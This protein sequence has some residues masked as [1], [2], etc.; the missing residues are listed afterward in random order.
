MSNKLTIMGWRSQGLRLPDYEVSLRRSSGAPYSITL[1]QMPNGTGKTTTL[2]LLRAALSGDLEKIGSVTQLEKRGGGEKSGL[3]EV[4]CSLNDKPYTYGIYIDFEEKVARIKTTRPT[5]QDDGHHVPPEF[6][7]FLRSNFVDFFVFDGELAESL[8]DSD[9]TN[10]QEALEALFHIDALKVMRSRIEE[11]WDDQVEH[12]TA[13]AERGLSRRRNRLKD[14][15]ARLG[16]L[17]DGYKDT[18]GRLREKRKKLNKLTEQYDAAIQKA[19]TW[20][21][22]VG[23]AQEAYV[24]ADEQLR[25]TSREVLDEMRN[26]VSL[27]DIFSDRCENLKLGLD[28]VKLPESAAREFFEEISNEEECI[29]GREIDASIASVIRERAASYLGNDDVALLN[30]IKS[31]ISEAVT[32]KRIDGRPLSKRLESVNVLSR[33]LSEAKTSLDALKNAAEEDDPALKEGRKKIEELN[34]EIRNLEEKEREFLSK[35]DS[36]GDQDT[37]GIDIIKRRIDD[38]EK[39]LTEIQEVMILKKKR[40]VLKDIFDKVVKGSLDALSK[41]IV[42]ETNSKLAAIIP[43]NEI[44]LSDIKKSLILKGQGGGSVGE[45]LSIA[46]SFLGTLFGHSNHELPLVV[47]SPAGPIDMQ[48]R[49][50]IAESIPRLT[51]QFIAFTI[52]SERQKFVDVLDN[53]PGSM[54]QYITLYRKSLSGVQRPSGDDKYVDSSDGRL[55]FGKGFFN[56]F[57]LESEQNGD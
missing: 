9:K 27:S 38:A 49:P 54:I 44:V 1:L 26:P 17:E 12:H 23:K 40:D 42:D 20:G 15:K 47:D 28:R 36:K 5:G 4:F 39:K 6:L 3:F 16:E 46:Y 19:K 53:L 29:C 37:Y 21:D 10:A 56:Q 51:H 31:S 7:K 41:N 33:N 55:V 43:D 8:L 52:S 24:R 25:S 50:R 13:K 22:Q 48:V 45:G 14:L 35:D 2:N 11:Y 32:G 30:A 34:N 18:V 57:Q